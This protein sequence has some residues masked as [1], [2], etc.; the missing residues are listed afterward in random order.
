MAPPHRFCG[1]EETSTFTEAGGSLAVRSSSLA[2]EV[3]DL[4]PQF[5]PVLALGFGQLAQRITAHTREV[6]IL[7]PVLHLPRDGDA[8][9]VRVLAEQGAPGCQIGPQPVEGLPTEAGTLAAVEFV[10]V[11]A[12]TA[13]GK[14]R[15]TGGVVAVGPAQVLGQL[16][17]G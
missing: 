1:V 14:R 4:L 15:G 13:A 17:L 6:G 11:L 7:Q 2:A 16:W 10:S 9:L 5:P 8:N 3:F 12:L